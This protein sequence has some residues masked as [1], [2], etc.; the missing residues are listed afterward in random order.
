ME[1]VKFKKDGGAVTAQISISGIVSWGYIYTG[2]M[3]FKDKGNNEVSNEHVLGMPKDLDK[4]TN[5]W[6]I[7]L[8][9]VTDDEQE[10]QVQ[11]AW[12][13]DGNILKEWRGSE[14]KKS[15]VKPDSIVFEKGDALL[16]AV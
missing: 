15:K 4:D 12:K 7:R 14:P 13:Q 2:D 3:D 9:N 5:T 1:L 8:A 6:N 11:I 10:Y 16:V